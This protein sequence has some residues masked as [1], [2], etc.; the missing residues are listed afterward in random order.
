MLNRYDQGARPFD[1]ILPR[2]PT[3]DP[4]AEKY[5]SVSPYVQYGNNL[6]NAVDPDG[7]EIEESSLREWEELKRQVERQRDK[8][9]SSVNKLTAKAEAKGWSA[10]KLAGKLVIRQKD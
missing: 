10:E 1:A 5:Y 6:V 9:Q 8:L 4:L 2:T 3:V 7:M